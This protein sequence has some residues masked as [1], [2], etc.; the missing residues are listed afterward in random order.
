MKFIVKGLQGIYTK[1]AMSPDKFAEGA[2]EWYHSL[3]NRRLQTLRVD[4]PNEEWGGPS[5]Q[6]W[7]IPAGQE[8]QGRPYPSELLAGYKPK[9]SWA[10]AQEH[11]VQNVLKTGGIY[12]T[13]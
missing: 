13:A 3:F 1:G 2:W 10:Q 5:D 9:Q 11:A 7:R 6:K 8:L 4:Y 12:L